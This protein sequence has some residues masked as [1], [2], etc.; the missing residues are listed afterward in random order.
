VPGGAVQ[1]LSSD[2]FDPADAEQRLDKRREGLREEI[3]RAEKKLGN[4][5]FVQKA[6]P[7]VVE[8]ERRK[9][10]EHRRALER[11]GE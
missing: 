3:V 1:V 11:L 4:E 10:E 6:P 2:A 5:R 9:L 7:E 8:E